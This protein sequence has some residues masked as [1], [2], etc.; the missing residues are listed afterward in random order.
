MESAAPPDPPSVELPVAEE[1]PHELVATPLV[2]LEL[3]PEEPKPR[4]PLPA[5]SPTERP[6][7][8]PL[9]LIATI[10]AGFTI[11]FLFV[12]TFAVEPFGVPTGSMAPTLLGNH[13]EARCPRCGFPVRVGS[14]SP[15]DWSDMACPNCGQRLSLARASEINGDRL[16]VDKNIYSLRS[17]RRWEVAVFRCPD[18]KDPLK[19][20]VKRVVGLPGESITIREGDAFA[21]GELLRKSLTEVREARVVVYDMNYVPTPGGW[22]QRWLV[23]PPESDRRLPK[24]F[25]RPPEPAD[26]SV[27]YKNQL[28]L[29]ASTSPQHECRVEYRNFDLDERTEGAISTWNS[30]DGPPRSFGPLPPAHDF[31]VE[32]TLE[33]QEAKSAGSVAI[34]LFD[35]G[36]AVAGELPVGAEGNGPVNV[37]NRQTGALG[38]GQTSTL[39]P[40]STY[41]IEFAFVD[42][43]VSLAVDGSLVVSP[44]DLPPLAKRGPVS[45]P[46][47][48]GVRGC[49]VAIR[50]LRITRDIYY[51]QYG[52]HGTR[53]PAQ[54]GLN[55]P[56]YFML[57]D[58]SGNSED[59]RKWLRP[60][61]PEANFIGKPFLIHQPLRVGR[62]SLA[63]RDRS[64]HTLDWS[65]LRWLH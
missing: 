39:R 7:C 60:G 27:L 41:Q 9:R 59:S 40:G 53:V 10:A 25:D 13:R 31:M 62:L 58:N 48:L 17:P 38:A 47:Q 42:R 29:D 44:I 61:V 35:G 14:P 34:G 8:S 21:N 11:L 5:A 56:E 1:L 3:P 63:G 54:L 18:P 15:T 49:K 28:S 12:R 19:P 65:R 57:G 30:Y 26:A 33:V 64:F 22:G 4:V 24:E 51:T 55:P 2:V 43:R 16:L 45:K 36:D 6:A 32:F 37:L 50:D 52:E 20:Y 46:L 23:Y